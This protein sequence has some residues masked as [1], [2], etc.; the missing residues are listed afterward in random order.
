MLHLHVGNGIASVTVI[1]LHPE[2]LL[3]YI[4][5]MVDDIC[6]SVMLCMSCSYCMIWQ[7][8]EQNYPN[9]QTNK[10]RANKQTKDKQLS[11]FILA[12]MYICYSY[13]MPKCLSSYHN[14]STCNHIDTVTLAN[15]YRCACSCNKSRCA[16][17]CAHESCTKAFVTKAKV[18]AITFYCALVTLC[19]V[20]DI[21]Q[22]LLCTC[23]NTIKI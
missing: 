13:A 12:I 22:L 8:N 3:L 23:R 15:S 20:V 21:V 7:P 10:Q 6:P 2:Y 4:Q 18:N 5:C 16:R 19:I 1:R 14:Y 11:D 17:A 9:K